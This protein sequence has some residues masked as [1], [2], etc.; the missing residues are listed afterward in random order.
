MRGKRKR[1]KGGEGGGGGG[2][3]GVRTFVKYTSVLKFRLDAE[4]KRDGIRSLWKDK[5]A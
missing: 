4:T 3:E 5:I 2:E 1:R